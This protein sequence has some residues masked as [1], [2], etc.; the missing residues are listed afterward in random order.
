MGIL[1]QKRGRNYLPHDIKA[2]EMAV[3]RVLEGGWP[4][5]GAC[6]YCHASRASLWRW[7]KAWGGTASSLAPKSHRP[8]SDHP[9]KEPAR[10]AEKIAGLLR[11][12]PSD[13]SIDAWVKAVRRGL[14]TSY[15]T[16]LRIMKRLGGHKPYRTSPKR[17]RSGRCE[18]PEL[19]G[20]KW[21]AD[22]KFVP[23]ECKAPGPEGKFCQYTY[24]DEATRKRHLHFAAEHSMHE[25]AV[26]PAGAIERFGYAPKE[27]QT[28]NGS[29]FTDRGLTKGERKAAGRVRAF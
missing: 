10:F 8:A 16:C 6:S 5:K 26:G 29:E 25:A 7:A 28:G 24:L 18:T 14:P 12:N 9:S 19:P 4:A 27:I 11:R 2:K 13:S 1:A 15:S 23:S 3:R 22:V 17:K 20:E 21:Q